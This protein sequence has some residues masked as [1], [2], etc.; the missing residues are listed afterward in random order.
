MDLGAHRVCLV[1]VARSGYHWWRRG[2]RELRVFTERGLMSI[3]QLTC[4]RVGQGRIGRRGKARAPEIGVRL[5]PPPSRP[6]STS[7]SN[8]ASIAEVNIVSSKLRPF[9][10]TMSLSRHI[11]YFSSTTH[12]S[13]RP[14][15]VRQPHA[16]AVPGHGIG[17]PNPSTPPS[18]LRTSSSRGC[19]L[20]LL[21]GGAKPKVQEWGAGRHG[22]G[23][24][25]R[26]R[27]EDEDWGGDHDVAQWGRR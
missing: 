24:M 26:W 14:Y 20:I 2:W 15:A 17:S 16:R 6:A 19:D 21:R 10:T 11:S 1:A 8:L 4:G 22:V 7:T 13:C 25:D 12:R 3:Q 27:M 23:S 9:V 18:A 5:S